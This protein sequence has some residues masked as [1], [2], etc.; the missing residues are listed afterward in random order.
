MSKLDGAKSRAPTTNATTVGNTTLVS[1]AAPRPWES[2]SAILSIPLSS[3]LS[4]AR[5]T[6]P[7]PRWRRGTA[8][9]VG[10]ETK[11]R[12]IGGRSA[13]PRAEARR[14]GSTSNVGAMPTS[15]TAKEDKRY[16]MVNS[17]KQDVRTFRFRCMV[18]VSFHNK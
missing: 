10:E 13:R 2:G 5:A 7:R 15:S 18:F 17:R 1:V 9:L 12:D 16:S 4:C 3:L 8:T 11:V 6:L 14:S